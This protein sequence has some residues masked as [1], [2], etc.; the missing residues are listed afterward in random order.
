[1]DMVTKKQ[2]LESI[3]RAYEKA[4]INGLY[5]V[6]SPTLSSYSPFVMKS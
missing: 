3:G 5:T 4:K 6:K 1:M 2:I